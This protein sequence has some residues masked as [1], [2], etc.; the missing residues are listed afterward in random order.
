MVSSSINS[1]ILQG[2]WQSL[3]QLLYQLLSSATA[4]EAFLDGLTLCSLPPGRTVAPLP[5][6]FLALDLD[7]MPYVLYSVVASL[8]YTDDSHPWCS[9]MPEPGPANKIMGRGVDEVRGFFTQYSLL[10]LVL[11]THPFHS[12]HLPCMAPDAGPLLNPRC[13][14]P[15]WKEGT[16]QAPMTRPQRTHKTC[17]HC[18]ISVA[19]PI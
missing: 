10:V 16:G 7:S 6:T 1:A 17:A 8:S 18:S 15:V 9:L 12:L 14:L 4:G 2:L 3:C 11:T 19:I 13:T 5:I